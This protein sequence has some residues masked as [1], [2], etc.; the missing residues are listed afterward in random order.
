MEAVIY[1]GTHVVVWLYASGTGLLSERVL[2][3][4]QHEEVI[5]APFDRLF[6]A[7]AGFAAAILIAKDDAIR[8]HSPKAIW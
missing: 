2:R 5:V 8:E 6:V 3:L 1:L 4:L 7:Q